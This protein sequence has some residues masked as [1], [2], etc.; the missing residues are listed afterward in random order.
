M[1]ELEVKKDAI[2]N[3][4]G[5]GYESTIYKYF[6]SDYYDKVVLYKKFNMFE[7]TNPDFLENKKQKLL[8][9][10]EI[11]EL[12]N[13]VKVL[14]LLY[15]DGKF[16]GYTM[17]KSDNEIFDM[18]D[19]KKIKI[20]LLKMIRDRIEILNSKGIYIGDFN[21]RNFLTSKDRSIIQMCD[22]DNL[23]IG[24]YDFDVCDKIEKR[25]LDRCGDLDALDSYCFNL[26]T[27]SFLGRFDI[28]YLSDYFTWEHVHKCLFTKENKEIIE[29]MIRLNS[30]YKKSYLID[31]IK[32]KS[33]F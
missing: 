1:R 24:E 18:F 30:N 7:H 21:E 6:D 19:K 14:D 12:K 9:I 22:L 29:S 16:T 10:P 26:F 17:E 25:F 33:L 32:T 31:N 11:E 20:K 28:G 3:T 4:F 5:C 13:D 23:R 8:L 27:I 15:T 2:Q